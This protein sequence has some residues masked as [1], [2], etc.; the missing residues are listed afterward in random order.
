MHLFCHKDCCPFP[1]GFGN[2]LAGNF[3]NAN[4]LPMTGFPMAGSPM[5][6]FSMS[7]F[8][9]SNFPASGFSQAAAQTT[10]PAM[11]QMPS[12]SFGFEHGKG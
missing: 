2:P 3:L 8:P 11:T 10:R 9:M 7:N 4:M 6:N 1:F 12:G 5:S